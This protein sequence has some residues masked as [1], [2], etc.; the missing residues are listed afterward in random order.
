MKLFIALFSMLLFGCNGSKNNKTEV[1]KSAVVEVVESQSNEMCPTQALP[2]E[3]TDR[4]Q[5]EQDAQVGKTVIDTTKIYNMG[6]VDNT[7]FTSNA[8][9]MEHM[10]K[11]KYPEN[12]E[13]MNGRGRIELTVE[14]D[15]RVSD[16]KI[17]KGIHPDLD[18]EFIRIFKM[19]RLERP[20]TI[21]GVPVRSKLEMPINSNV[22]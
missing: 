8:A 21:D 4:V 10:K 6:E 20:A 17:I 19:L 22:G 16:V 7:A 14:R 2:N 1:Q 15:G 3:P 12:L 13:P 5:K 11:F 18:K 9:L